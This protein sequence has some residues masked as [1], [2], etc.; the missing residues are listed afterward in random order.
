MGY[1]VTITRTDEITDDG[2]I[3]KEEWL[4]FAA[5]D[6]ELEIEDKSED[7][8]TVIWKRGKDSAELCWEDAGVWSQSP[9]NV[10]ILKMIEIAGK[11]DA[12]VINE[13]GTVFIA[14]E[15]DNS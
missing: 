7:F 11:M 1:Q 4:N 10:T 12:K 13:D 2:L 15:N 6:P 8:P 5:A 9:E 14:G 3:S